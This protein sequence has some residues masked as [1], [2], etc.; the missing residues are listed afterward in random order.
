MSELLVVAGEASGDRAA[1]LVIAALRAEGLA[2]HVFGM[3]GS[4]LASQGAELVSD[5]RESTALGVT[6]VAARACA[7]RKAYMTVARAARKRRARAALLVNYT[8]FNT[9]LAAR[10]PRARDSR[11]LVRRTADLGLASGAGGATPTDDRSDGGDA[12]LRRSPL[13]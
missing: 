7:I 9:F 1:A 12:P 2:E 5:L 4:S 10:L 3:G 11:P 13:A 8:E 6:D